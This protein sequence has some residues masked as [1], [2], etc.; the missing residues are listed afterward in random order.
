MI[1]SAILQAGSKHWGIIWEGQDSCFGHSSDR[2]LRKRE[3]VWAL[4]S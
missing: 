4:K 3:D 2:M 1:E